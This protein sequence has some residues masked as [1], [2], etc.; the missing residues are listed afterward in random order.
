[1]FGFIFAS[2]RV[3]VSVRITM[4]S[5]LAFVI[6]RHITER[7][8]Q[9]FRNEFMTVAIQMYFISIL[10]FKSLIADFTK[11]CVWN[12]FFKDTLQSVFVFV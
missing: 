6:K 11:F 12:D 10:V 8:V 7:A 4:N 3:Q 9:S 2:N 5:K 1:V